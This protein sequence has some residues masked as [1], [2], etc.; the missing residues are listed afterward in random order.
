MDRRQF[1]RFAALGAATGCLP[2]RAAKPGRVLIA[3]A[4]MAGLVAAWELRQAGYEVLV[5]EASARSGGRVH[6]LR[7]PFS[8]GLHAEA[9][10]GRIPNTH[11]LTLKYVRMLGLPLKPFYPSPNTDVVYMGGHREVA[12]PGK[13][14]DLTQFGLKLTAREQEVG[15]DGLGH[16]YLADGVR[17]CGQATAAG[18]PQDSLRR[19]GGV[20]IADF[21]KAKGASDS[22]MALICSGF[23]T[24]SAI[25]FLRD[26]AS[27]EVPQL[28]KIPGGNDR[29]PL[30]LA[31]KLS[32][33][34]TYGA[35][36]VKI[37]PTGQNVEVTVEQGGRQQ[38]MTGDYL[39]TTLPFTVLRHIEI[40]PG[41]SEAKQ[42][43]IREMKYGAVSRV[44]VQTKRRVW[45][46][47]GN[48][49]FARVDRPMEVWHPTWDQPGPRG[50]LVA[51]TYQELAQSIAAQSPQERIQK[52]TAYFD[53]IHPGCQD[54]FELGHS[55][56]WNEQP[57]ARGAY[58]IADP[59]ATHTL[60]PAAM[61]TESRVLFA[62]EHCSSRHG[63]IQGAIESSLRSVAQILK[64]TA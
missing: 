58:A 17:E 15:L 59:G 53:Q 63:W 61:A 57:Y 31:A 18:W 33:V 16:L 34:I 30:A 24:D 25:D 47:Q 46:A 50:L 49:G 36:I 12:Q 37:Q 22:A 48:T 21:L 13:A 56:V 27:H 8:D 44:Y 11:D 10:A 4:G 62:G 35:R 51:Y 6:T 32:G 45:N 9:G 1:L 20:T 64:A 14:L 60:L 7:A 26:L 39:I 52:M 41:F 2:A 43:A 19:Y 55:W 38:V 23:E 40:T 29:L 3:G 42:R 28:Y 54:N 5:L